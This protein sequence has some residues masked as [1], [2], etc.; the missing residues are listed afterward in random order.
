MSGTL[1]GVC[2]FD[3][4][5][6]SLQSQVARLKEQSGRLQEECE[7][8]AQREHASQEGCRK[9]QRQLRELREDCASLQQREAEAHQRCHEL[10]RHED[11][12]RPVKRLMLRAAGWPGC[13]SMCRSIE[14]SELATESTEDCRPETL[15]IFRS[16]GAQCR[17]VC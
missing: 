10:V 2:W 16:V 15:F 11:G 9:L 6:P 7:Q 4:V 5:P 8:A 3:A 1:V 14:T 13:R 12:A 17:L